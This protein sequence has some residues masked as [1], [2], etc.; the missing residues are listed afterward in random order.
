MLCHEAIATEF[1]CQLLEESGFHVSSGLTVYSDAAAF[2]ASLHHLA[3]S[4]NKIVVYEVLDPL[5]ASDD[6]YWVHREILAFISNKGNLDKLVPQAFLPARSLVGRQDLLRGNIQLPVVIKVASDEPSNGGLGVRVCRSPSD[7]IAMCDRFFP[8]DS[9]VVEELIHVE[10]NYG[11]SFAVPRTGPIVY[12][13]G[14]EQIIEDHVNYAGTWIEDSTRVSSGI[15]EGALEAMSRAQTLGF[16]GFAGAD[17]LVST[18]GRVLVVDLN[19][20]LT[21]ATPPRLFADSILSSTGRTVLRPE[22]FVASA[23]GDTAARFVRQ[24]RRERRFVPRYILP[25]F[26]G[27]SGS[28]VHGFLLGHSRAEIEKL[29]TFM[30]TTLCGPSE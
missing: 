24:L 4:G 28:M 5:E 11:L 26:D 20:R 6:S 8:C 12:L 16:Y 27:R 14:S 18:D 30:F 7:I 25:R 21:T 23:T 22:R 17:V 2:L 15:A 13:G 19:F 29:R 9:F 10:K 1:M 3:D